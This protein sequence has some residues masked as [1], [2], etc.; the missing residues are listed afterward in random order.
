MCLKKDRKDE[1]EMHRYQDKY[2]VLIPILGL[3]MLLLKYVLI[4]VAHA[5]I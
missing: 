1:L 5:C 3:S 2:R 4:P